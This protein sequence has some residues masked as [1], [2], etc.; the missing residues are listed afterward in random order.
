MVLNQAPVNTAYNRIKSKAGAREEK[1]R[2]IC[3]KIRKE[4]EEYA[5]LEKRAE[6]K[7]KKKEA[8]K[9]A[10]KEKKEKRKR[11]SESSN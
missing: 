6:K 4:L 1:V 2:D 11:R 9:E 10:K 5:S 8:K 7:K 3:E